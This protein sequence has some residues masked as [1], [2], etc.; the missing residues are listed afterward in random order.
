MGS[1]MRKMGVYLGLLEDTDRYDDEYYDGYDESADQTSRPRAEDP[2][3]PAP[4]SASRWIGT[5]S[6]RTRSATPSTPD[7]APRNPERA[8]E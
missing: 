5:G 2:S 6:R 3:R 4:V 8:V 1:A 7:P